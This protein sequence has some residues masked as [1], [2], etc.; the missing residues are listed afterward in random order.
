MEF[1]TQALLILPS[2]AFMFIV[3]LILKKQTSIAETS[4]SIA[5]KKERQQH[6]L[7]LRVD[8]YQ[9]MILFME[10]ISPN[11]LI[12]RTFQNEKPAKVFQTELLETIRQEYEHNVAQQLFISPKGWK[13]I[14][15][16]KEEIVKIINLAA[17]QVDENATSLDLSS[18][19]FEITSQLKHI[20]TEVTNEILISELQG[21]F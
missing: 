7:P 5:L 9:R 20:P 14:R 16:S 1:I 6:F 19:I 10:R 3:I 15:E 17:S 8:A 18:K 21:L 4:N 13:L 2:I 11:S 12:M